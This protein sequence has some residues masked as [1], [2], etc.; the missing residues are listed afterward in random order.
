MANATKIIVP[1]QKQPAPFNKPRV[2]PVE[3]NSITPATI[4]HQPLHSATVSGRIAWRSGGQDGN[5]ADPI[6]NV[7]LPQRAIFSPIR[8]DASKTLL[9][10]NKAKN[11]SRNAL[12]IDFR[13]NENVTANIPVSVLPSNLKPNY[14]GG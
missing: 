14:S 2:Q 1:P 10:L 3:G 5:P 12:G 8:A 6:A 9:D 11:I 13:I 4:A 7:N